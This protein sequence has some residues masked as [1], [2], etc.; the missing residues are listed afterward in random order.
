MREAVF[1]IAGI[2]VC[3]GAILP[4][5]VQQRRSPAAATPTFTHDVAPI[6]YRNCV[7]CHRPGEMAPMSLLSYADARPWARAIAEEVRDGRMPPWH[8]EAP[9]GTFHGERRLTDDEKQTIMA[10]ATG[11]APEGDAADLPPL[12]SFAEGWSIGTPDVILEMPEAYDVPADGIVNYEYFYIPTTFT[13][14]TWVQAVEVRPGNR[15]V[16]HH[17]LAYYRAAP[18]LQRTALLTPS[19]PQPPP[20]SAAGKRPPQSLP[21]GRRLIGSYAPG[22][23]PQVMPPGTALRLEAGGIIELQVHYTTTGEAASDRTKVGFVLSRD[24]KP[25][26]VLASAFLNPTLVLPPGKKDVRVDADVTFLQDATVW[27]LFPHT[28]VRGKRWRYVLELPDGF[29]QTV[30]DIPRYDFNWQTY[31]IF[32]APLQVPRGAKLIATAWYDNSAENRSNPDPKMEVRWGDQVWDEMHY[33]GI[34][35][36][37]GR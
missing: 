29:R 31:Y 30:L 27:G 7:S 5:D 12:P 34:L 9:R 26:E 1:T 15:Q 37:P 18:D 35:V 14:P 22:T 6:F 3:I 19:H 4:A 33:T 21:Y 16:V 10:W 13:E 17:A 36:S 20:P 25:R 28:H 2:A 32:K 23:N 24:P 11:G 8:A